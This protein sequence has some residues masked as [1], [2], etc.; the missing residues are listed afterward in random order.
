MNCVKAAKEGYIKR[1][2]AITLLEAQAATGNIIDPLTGRKLS[3]TEAAEIGYID[4][5][6]Q[7]SA[8]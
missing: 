4:K 8:F 1:P 7:A 3:V 2:T 6:R 5:V